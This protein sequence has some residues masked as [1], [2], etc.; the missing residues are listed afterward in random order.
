MRLARRGIDV[1][2]RSD[3]QQQH[4]AVA[5]VREQPVVAGPACRTGASSSG[6]PGAILPSK[7]SAS[8]VFSAEPVRC[9]GTDSRPELT[10]AR[11]KACSRASVS[12]ASRKS[13]ETWLFGVMKSV[14][15]VELSRFSSAAATRS[16]L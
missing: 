5:G 11:A 1:A 3:E 7:A 12:T 4:E 9:A 14:E 13:R 16:S 2:G 8:G 15:R 10:S 6:A